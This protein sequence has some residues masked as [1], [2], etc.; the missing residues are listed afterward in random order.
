MLRCWLVRL[1][2]LLEEREGKREPEGGVVF[3]FLIAFFILLLT[4]RRQRY[5]NDTSSITPWVSGLQRN[6]PNDS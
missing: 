1:N 5:N 6:G 2:C 4:R 3:T